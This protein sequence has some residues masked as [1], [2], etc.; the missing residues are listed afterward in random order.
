[1]AHRIGIADCS[2][3]KI[4]AQCA[5]AYSQVCKVGIVRRIY[6]NGKGKRCSGAAYTIG[7]KITS[8]A[9]PKF[10]SKVAI[11]EQVAVFMTFT[12]LLPSK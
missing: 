3:R 9:E 8:D 7:N 11:I 6:S 12:P 1:M 5:I 4:R 10:A 2:C